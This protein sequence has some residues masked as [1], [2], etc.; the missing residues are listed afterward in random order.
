MK[1][2]YECGNGTRTLLGKNCKDGL[3]QDEKNDYH[4]DSYQAYVHPM[5]HR[6]DSDSYHDM[7]RVIDGAVMW[8][9]VFLT[10]ASMLSLSWPGPT[11]LSHPLCDASA[12][13]EWQK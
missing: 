6:D 9:T 4:N 8:L 2:I 10:W 1:L 11:F 5:G 3:V 7:I 13:I 12:K